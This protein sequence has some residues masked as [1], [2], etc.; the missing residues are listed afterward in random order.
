M[1]VTSNQLIAQL[2][3]MQKIFAA[4]KHLQTLH[5]VTEDDINVVEAA[6]R[7][8]RHSLSPFVRGMVMFDNIDGTVPIELDNVI[9]SHGTLVWSSFSREVM[10]GMD[11]S[12]EHN[13]PSSYNRDMPLFAPSSVYLRN[14]LVKHIHPY[15]QRTFLHPNP[16]EIVSMYRQHM[17]LLPKLL[18][19]PPK[20]HPFE[21]YINEENG[22][23]LELVSLYHRGYY[24]LCFAMGITYL[25]RAITD[26]IRNRFVWNSSKHIKFN[27]ILATSELRDL[28]GRDVVF[29]L[30]LVCGPTQ[31]MSLRNVVWHGVLN[32][33][34]FPEY[35]ASLL[36]LM[37]V[38]LV[39]LPGVKEALNDRSQLESL[40]E[41]DVPIEIPLIDY[42]TMIDSTFFLPFRQRE[43]WKDALQF[44]NRGEHYYAAILLFPLLE[45]SLR[46]LFAICNERVEQIE[47]TDT[48]AVY[49]TFED[50]LSPHLGYGIGRNKLFDELDV[51]ILHVVHD[52]MV[53]KDVQSRIRIAHGVLDP[54]CIPK[55]IIDR[56]IVLII[57]LCKKYEYKSTEHVSHDY[58]PAFHPQKKLASELVELSDQ[59][60]TFWNDTIL[61]YVEKEL[62]EEN[63]NSLLNRN[64]RDQV[65]SLL[66]KI[67]Q[68]MTTKFNYRS[69]FTAHMEHT[70]PL[71]QYHTI[72][73]YIPEQYEGQVG[74][75]ITAI[76]YMRKSCSDVKQII[77]AVHDAILRAEQKSQLKTGDRKR[78]E[79]HLEKLKRNMYPLYLLLVLILQAC[80]VGLL[81]M[82]KGR[83]NVTHS[84]FMLSSSLLASINKNEW[85]K[86]NVVKRFTDGVQNQ[87]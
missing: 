65:E 57:F 81:N 54:H 25:E 23:F 9:T 36:L 82:N 22:L 49:V 70:A 15:A 1:F 78:G 17:S 68:Y 8:E 64:L 31:G 72:P 39:E 77:S 35:Y 28:L 53:W 55:S 44:Y 33:S 83:S 30:K 20:I 86:Q 73:Y 41:F 42:N 47:T 43:S 48:E 10:S 46:R 80:E 74:S 56:I 4:G 27:D 51:N 79:K 75:N 84:C 50:S 2:E 38:S 21:H 5:S 3:A 34:E 16:D 19:P 29:F 45:H 18:Q 67:D 14:V 26:M 59:M 52:V 40:M 66:L 76:E 37:I 71:I 69:S 61:E 7:D 12:Q 62:I 13:I 63:S 58:T 11:L 85:P 87:L 24:L 32:D 6:L 60:N